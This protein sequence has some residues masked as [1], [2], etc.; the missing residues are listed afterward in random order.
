MANTVKF[1][2]KTGEALTFSAF[3]PDG[4]ARGVAD[5]NLPEI[6][7]TGYYTA[8][9][10][11]E[12][13]A[14]DV[15]VVKNA[16]G[17]VVGFGEYQPETSSISSLGVYITNGYFTDD[18]IIGDLI[19]GWD[20]ITGDWSVTSGVLTGHVGA[21][22]VIYQNINNMVAG[23]SYT[24][25]YTLGADLTG[26]SLAINTYDIIITSDVVSAGD[27]EY[28]FTYDSLLYRR[29]VILQQ[30]GVEISK[31]SIEETGDALPTN[32]Y[33]RGE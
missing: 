26:L 4:T 19:Y 31:I 13:L 28:I 17:K 10:S 2:Y 16:A 6:G 12:L 3:E 20:Y 23:R 15:V 11:T 1:G 9:P 22:G 8:T 33:G 32:V 27:Y 25:K 7:A 29:L 24:L 5:Q 30:D 14:G 21:D 18:V